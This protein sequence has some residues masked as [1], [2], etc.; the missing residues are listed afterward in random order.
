MPTI[1]RL[2]PDESMKPERIEIL[3]LQWEIVEDLR[4]E[5]ARSRRA[6]FAV[7]G[8][9]QSSSLEVGPLSRAMANKITR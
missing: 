7:V 3:D 1:R 2:R 8:D 5:L 9:D 4:R 6:A